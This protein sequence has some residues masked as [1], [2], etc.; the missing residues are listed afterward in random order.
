MPSALFASRQQL[1]STP[2]RRCR[3]STERCTTVDFAEK[4]L[5]LLSRDPRAGDAP[6][7]EAGDPLA[8]LRR[9]FPGLAEQVA[10]REVLDFGC[11][12]GRQSAALAAL[13]ARRG[14]GSDTSPRALGKARA[15]P[16]GARR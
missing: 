6:A 15:W 12:A 7:P 8:L 1:S 14:V 3:A 4:L 5:L 11:G 13:G 10:G 16:G 9:V 2:A